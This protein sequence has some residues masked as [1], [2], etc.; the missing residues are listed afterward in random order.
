MSGVLPRFELFRWTHRALNR[1]TTVR[2]SQTM[3]TMM[4]ST[5]AYLIKSSAN[6]TPPKLASLTGAAQHVSAG[7]PMA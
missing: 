1:S 7:T 2:S 3:P 5:A 4:A 6:R